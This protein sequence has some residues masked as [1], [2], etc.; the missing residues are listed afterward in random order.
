M[1]TTKIFNNT[2]RAFS[3]KSESELNR[4]IFMF[5]MMGM[6][7]MVKIGTT[8]TNLSLNLHLPVE[9]LIKKTIFNQFCGG[10]TEEDCLPTIRNIYTKQLHGI[11]DYS[12]EGKETEEEFDAATERKLNIIKFI[13]DKP[14]IP[15]GVFK[16]TGV[17]KFAIWEKVSQKETLTKEEQQEWDTIKVRVEK[18]CKTAH[19]LGTCILVDGEE[20]WMQDAADDLMEEM[21]HK[22]NKERVVIFNTIKCYRRD[23]LQ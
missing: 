15:F 16:P 22:Y 20:T 2:K 10:V 9:G 14:E 5:K 17:G 6:P 23:R 11:L 12:V 4:A 21:M 19:D 18:L 7:A 8:L 1:M 13:A 3:L